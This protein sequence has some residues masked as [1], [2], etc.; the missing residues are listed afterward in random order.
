M[1]GSGSEEGEESQ[2]YENTH[3][4]VDDEEDETVG[5]EIFRRGNGEEKGKEDA[6]S[7]QGAQS[8]D[9]AETCKIR[10]EGFQSGE[11]YREDSRMGKEIVQEGKAQEQGKEDGAKSEEGTPSK[12]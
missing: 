11:D 7:Q 8:K 9:G 1:D 6:E 2:Q 5:E 12:E 4:G 10:N 3:Q